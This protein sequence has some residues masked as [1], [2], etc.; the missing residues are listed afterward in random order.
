[1]KENGIDRHADFQTRFLVT[2]KLNP[3]CPQP[4]LLQMLESL[5]SHWV[6]LPKINWSS[7]EVVDLD[8]RE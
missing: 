6:L 5:Y 4:L 7:E 1:M 2:L 8:E 3:S